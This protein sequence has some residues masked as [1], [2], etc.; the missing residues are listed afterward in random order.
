MTDL[1]FFILIFREPERSGDQFLRER[2]AARELVTGNRPVLG[3]QVNQK[4][5]L[6]MLGVL[7]DCACMGKKGTSIF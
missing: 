3:S 1:L 7:N 5:S 4:E 2:G 6:R